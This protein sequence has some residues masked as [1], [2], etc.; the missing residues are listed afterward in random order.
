MQLMILE[1]RETPLRVERYGVA[2]DRVDHHNFEAD[3][4]GSSRNLHQRVEQQ[5]RSDATA[6]AARVKAQCHLASYFD[7][8]RYL[9]VVAGAGA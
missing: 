1:L 8:Y 3:V 5:L 7:S 2:V 4:P 9:P 6:L